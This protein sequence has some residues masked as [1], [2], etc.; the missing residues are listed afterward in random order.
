[1]ATLRV[2]SEPD[3]DGPGRAGLRIGR[4]VTAADRRGQGL[5]GALV[6]HVLRRPG[7]FVLDAQ[8]YLTDWYGGFGFIP[9]GREFLLD[10]IPH[11]PMRRS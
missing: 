11:T 2:L 3:A 1:M 10:G 8:S 7:P 6:A 5:A 9:T 4:V